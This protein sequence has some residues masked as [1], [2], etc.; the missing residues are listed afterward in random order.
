MIFLTSWGALELSLEMFGIHI[1]LAIAAFFYCA[2]FSYKAE[3][4]DGDTP[5]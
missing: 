2:V 1:T 4:K 5:N 3:P